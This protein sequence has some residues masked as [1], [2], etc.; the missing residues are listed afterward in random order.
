MV[1]SGYW[2]SARLAFGRR[3]TKKGSP[4]WV[5]SFECA[6]RPRL[7]KSAAARMSQSFLSPWQWIRVRSSAHPPFFS[8]NPCNVEPDGSFVPIS[9]C[10]QCGPHLRATE[11]KKRLATFTAFAGWFHGF[12]HV[13]GDLDMFKRLCSIYGNHNSLTVRASMTNAP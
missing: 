6:F 10:R 11:R 1:D 3:A 12:L 2:S 9:W 8:G 4:L 7:G 5:S 13:P